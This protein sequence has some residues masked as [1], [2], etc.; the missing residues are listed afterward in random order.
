MQDDMHSPEDRA[1]NSALEADVVME[2]YDGMTADP[3]RMMRDSQEILGAIRA[4]GCLLPEE[5]AAL[6]EER[7]EAVAVCDQAV[8]VMQ[9][10]MAERDAARAEV[11]QAEEALR[12]AQKRLRPAYGP[13]SKKRALA[14]IDAALTPP[15][16]AK[17]TADE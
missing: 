7:D 13:L 6:R 9:D 16:A 12:E 10:C 4:L 2:I 14:I 17:D 15:P 8:G 11:A 1:R 5:A 3:D